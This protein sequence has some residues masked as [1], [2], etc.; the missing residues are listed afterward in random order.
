MNRIQPIPVRLRF[1]SMQLKNRKDLARDR[2]K[3]CAARMESA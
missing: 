3:A 1:K 2:A